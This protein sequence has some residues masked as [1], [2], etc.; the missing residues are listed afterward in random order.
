MITTLDRRLHAFRPDLA[1][2]ALKG[3]V[4][5]ERFVAGEAMQVIR[6]SAP[7]HREPRKD[8]PVD[9]EALCGERAN[10][11]ELAEGWAWCQL[12]S[13]GYV[14]YLP[15]ERLS[16]PSPQASHRVN[17]VRSFAY[18]GPSMKLPQAMTLSL[19]SRVHLLDRQ[20]DFAIVAGVAGLARSYVWAQHLKALD[21]HEPDPVSVAEKLLHAPYLWGGKSSLGLD[22]S[23]LVQLALDAVGIAAPRDSDMQERSVG[24]PLPLGD[25]LPPLRRGDL[26]FWKGHVGLMQDAHQ[27]LHA[28]GHH[29]L[30]A[31]E[32]LQVAIDRIETKGG[33]KITS[34]RRTG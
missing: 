17:A 20:G 27:L 7:L 3:R 4:E 32:P 16:A 2:L 1:D 23:G 11:F 24:A 28:N 12:A 5:A 30:V 10:V 31:S 9:T 8:A 21:H 25:G 18:P 34:I 6:H 13:D 19:G 15:A 29:M 14:G 33:G 26:V 22:C